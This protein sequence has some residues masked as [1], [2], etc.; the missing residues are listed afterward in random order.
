MPAG[1]IYI[2]TLVI[3]N[4]P[5]ICSIMRTTIMVYMLGKPAGIR[6]RRSTKVNRAFGKHIVHPSYS[7]FIIAVRREIV[8]QE[9]ATSQ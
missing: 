9:F 5:I 4:I 2:A 3:T 8:P 1:I 6:N 7:V